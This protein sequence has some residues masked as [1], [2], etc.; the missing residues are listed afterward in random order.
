MYIH[1]A[2]AEEYA[3]SSSNDCYAAQLTRIGNISFSTDDLLLGTTKHNRPLYHTG[4]TRECKLPRIQINPR[5]ALNVMPL[6]ALS[7]LGIL[8]SKLNG[9]K[10]L[11]SGDNVVSQRE[12][13]MI[14]P[15][16]S[17]A[18]LK[19]SSYLLSCRWG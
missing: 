16:M 1:K 13:G 3:T 8:V 17:S 15:Q 2:Q 19:I 9:T 6:K 18:K 10:V 12:I 14:L 5:S 4:Y 11:I 7:L